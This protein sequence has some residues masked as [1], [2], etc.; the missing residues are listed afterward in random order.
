MRLYFF[1]NGRV[2]LILISLFATCCAVAQETK[3]GQMICESGL[4]AAHSGPLSKNSDEYEALATFQK[5]GEWP[6]ADQAATRILQ[7]DPDNVC[8]LAVA[9]YARRLAT[10]FDYKDWT[11]DGKRGLQLLASWRNPRSMP[12]SEYKKQYDAMA[13]VFYGAAGSVP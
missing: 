4:T 7:D 11:I 3:F 8:A 2:I 12:N 9:L 13:I 1:Q 10:V 6:K 5:A